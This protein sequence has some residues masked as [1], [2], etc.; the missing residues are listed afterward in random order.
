MEVFLKAITQRRL[1]LSPESV[2]L[3]RQ[4]LRCSKTKKPYSFRNE[5][6]KSGFVPIVIGILSHP[7]KG[8]TRKSIALEDEYLSGKLGKYEVQHK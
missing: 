3:L 8:S 4:L 1:M 5:G 7:Q 6:L 2:R